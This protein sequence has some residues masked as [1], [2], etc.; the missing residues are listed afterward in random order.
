MFEQSL[1]PIDEAHNSKDEGRTNNRRI[2]F[3]EGNKDISFKCNDLNV[4]K[5]KAKVPSTSRAIGELQLLHEKFRLMN[6]QLSTSHDNSDSL[7]IPIGS[8]QKKL[9]LHQN[10]IS[11][12]EISIKEDEERQAKL[13]ICK[14]NLN[15]HND[16]GSYLNDF[17]RV[18]F[19][20]GF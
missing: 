1:Q 10:N 2:S 6:N 4:T 19:S 14:Q 9:Q 15:T 8:G 5:P 11:F 20:D 13:N 16:V 18:K 3:K 17:I 7:F 12:K